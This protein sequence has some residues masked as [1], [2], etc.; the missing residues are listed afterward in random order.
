[1]LLEL[2]LFVHLFGKPRDV[3][4]DQGS[5]RFDFR[6][7]G[8]G[9]P[10]EKPER[11][12]NEDQNQRQRSK[13]HQDALAAESGLTGLGLFGKA[14]GSKAKRFKYKGHHL[15]AKLNGGGNQFDESSKKCD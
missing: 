3:L 9:P 11:P 13:R 1:M 14:P 15:E 5:C 8:V 6:S 12:T 2:S 4:I 10:L 7:T